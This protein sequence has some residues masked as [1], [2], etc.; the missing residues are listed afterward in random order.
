MLEMLRRMFDETDITAMSADE[1]VDEYETRYGRFYNILED[2]ERDGYIS[3]FNREH[4]DK[5]FEEAIKDFIAENIEEVA[6]DTYMVWCNSEVEY[7]EYC[8]RRC[9]YSGFALPE[10]WASADEIL[11]EDCAN[12]KLLDATE[13][14]I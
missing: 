4:T 5:A 7:C 13:E 14:E 10:V 12:C 2:A 9:S 3:E 11:C 8:G 1:Q 6:D